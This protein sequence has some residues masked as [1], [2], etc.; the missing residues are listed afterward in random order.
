MATRHLFTP[1]AREFVLLAKQ[2]CGC[3]RSETS[4]SS[5]ASSARSFYLGLPLGRIEYLVIRVCSS[6]AFN[7]ATIFTRMNW[8]RRKRERRMTTA[9]TTNPEAI[10]KCEEEC[11]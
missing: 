9:W 5:F 4:Q 11:N 1:V 10:R 8:G 6:R 3:F 2:L 7:V